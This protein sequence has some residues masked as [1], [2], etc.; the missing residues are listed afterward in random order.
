MDPTPEPAHRVAATVV[1][2]LLVVTAVGVAAWSSSLV[3]S[4]VSGTHVGA[5]GGVEDLSSR[6]GATF[7]PG[8]I[9]GFGS[10]DTTVLIAGISAWDKPAGR[11]QPVLASLTAGGGVVNETPSVARQFTD[12]GVFGTV[13]NG[14]AWLVSGEA[15]WGSLNEG[16]LLSYSGGVW[17]NLT[18]VLGPY[19]E[20]G[21]I[22]AVGWNGS[23]WL[24]AG[25]TSAGAVM[26]GYAAGVP[27][28]LTN[29][30]PPQRAGDWIQLLVWNGD[31]WMIGGKGVFGTL[32][33][34]H[35]TDLLAGSPFR[36][37][38]AYAADWNGTA[39]LVGGGLPAA[40][41]IVEGGS[42]VA[43][44]ALPAGFDRWVNAIV[45]TSAGWI[46]GGKGSASVPGD[47]GSAP[48]LAVWS[49]YHASLSDLS[50]SLPAAFNGGQVQFAWWAP[51]LGPH[52]VLIV[53]QGDL[54][55]VTGSSVG[56]MAELDVV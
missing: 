12:G 1:V 45:W 33:L 14:S 35:Y 10:N 39:W 41:V 50:A 2:L 46:V 20:N 15:T 55:S 44:P 48:E 22:W 32:A 28:N 18:P 30:L 24:L 11:T 8:A 17:T 19:F 23:S 16:V 9:Q 36:L 7:H 5:I 51:I 25:N 13:W 29:L 38:G 42:L 54:N 26:V 27:T 6:L 56:A 3:G 53:G 47:L 43:A 40:L 52:V 34:G 31:A 21:G 37:G 49:P 4:P